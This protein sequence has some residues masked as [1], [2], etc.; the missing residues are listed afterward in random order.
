MVHCYEHV[1]ESTKVVHQLVGG[2]SDTLFQLN[3]RQCQILAKELIETT[4]FLEKRSVDCSKFGEGIGSISLQHLCSTIKRAE[5]L[6]KKCCCKDLESWLVSAMML[7]EIQEDF[8]VILLDI[9]LWRRLLDFAIICG[10][11]LSQEKKVEEMKI[12]DD[13]Y[14]QLFKDL[15]RQSHALQQVAMEDKGTIISRTSRI[16]DLQGSKNSLDYLRAIYLQS[17]LT[18]STSSRDVELIKYEFVD[19]LG[20]GGCGTVLK[21]KWLGIECALKMLGGQDENEATTLKGLFHPNIIR[22]FYYWEDCSKNLR[23]HLLM[24]LMPQ[25]LGAYMRGLLK[26]VSSSKMKMGKGSMPF[27][28]PVAIDIMYQIAQAMCYVHEK[29]LTHRDLKPANILVKERPQVGLTCNDGEGYLDIKLADFGLVKSYTNTSTSQA[30]SKNKGIGMYRAPEIFGKDMSQKR[31]Y[32]PMVD[33]WSF[34]ITCLEILSGKQAYVE[35]GDMSPLD[36][37]T[38]I[39]EEGLRPTLP[40]HCPPYLAFCIKSC[41]ELLPYRR[42]TFASLCKLLRH[43][44]L[45]SLGVTKLDDS[46]FFFAYT[47]RNDQVQSLDLSPLSLTT[48]Y[49]KQCNFLVFYIRWL[50]VFDFA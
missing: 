2:S 48:R 32:L 29:H 21:V 37:Q 26:G 15:R 12:M 43:A 9:H 10:R 7:V 27:S 42:P 38:M 25:D 45:L 4:T 23:S 20:Q 39:R 34:G 30:H 6:V 28:L 49:F 36:L 22:L 14:H 41:W 11:G 40:K 46:K 17:W 50:N 1:I 5:V 33:V 19:V 3:E 16:V 18:S 35:Y 13:E 44:K 8:M 24:E 47:T 31:H